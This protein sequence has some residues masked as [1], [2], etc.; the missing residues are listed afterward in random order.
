MGGAIGGA[1][2]NS[3]NGA[4]N[5]EENNVENNDVEDDHESDDD[6]FDDPKYFT[7]N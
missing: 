1:K 6:L 7:S 5:I 2:S 4:R 3:P